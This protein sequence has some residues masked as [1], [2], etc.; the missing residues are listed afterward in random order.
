MAGGM[1]V[2]H[3]IGLGGE[4]GDHR[5]RRLVAARCHS[6]IVD[7]QIFFGVADEKDLVAA[8]FIDS[9]ADLFRGLCGEI[10]CD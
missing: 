1:V 2:D 6:D 8:R 9:A 3:H 4:L 7:D 5:H 10:F